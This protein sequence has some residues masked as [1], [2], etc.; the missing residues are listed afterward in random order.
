MMPSLVA[1]SRTSGLIINGGTAD[2]L[3]VVVDAYSP[4]CMWLIH[5]YA[6][7]LALN[8]GGGGGIC[9][10]FGGLLEPHYK[11]IL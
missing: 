2:F 11:F 8:R 4:E 3:L 10:A 9:N 5:V 6:H 1:H 7:F